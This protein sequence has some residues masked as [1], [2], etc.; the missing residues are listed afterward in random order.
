MTRSLTKSKKVVKRSHASWMILGGLN[1]TTKSEIGIRKGQ[2][3]RP[4]SMGRNT[5]KGT[6]G[7]RT[8]CPADESD[9]T[10]LFLLITKAAD[11]S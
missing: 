3:E 11:V 6:G 7:K 1:A 8:S 9:R 10:N 5:P 2:S 4:G